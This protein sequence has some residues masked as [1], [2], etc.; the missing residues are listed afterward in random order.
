MALETIGIKRNGSGSTS[1]IGLST[2]VPRS[3]LGSRSGGDPMLDGMGFRGRPEY[4][5]GGRHNNSNRLRLE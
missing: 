4:V 2:T 3:R 1:D 5:V